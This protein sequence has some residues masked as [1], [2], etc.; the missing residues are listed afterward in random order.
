MNSIIF[1]FF[2]NQQL[3]YIYN[4]FCMSLI[5][6]MIINN[7]TILMSVILIHVAMMLNFQKN[8]HNFSHYILTIFINDIHGGCGIF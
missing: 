6:I 1:V 2:F 5:N 3:I 8:L 4:I 7:N